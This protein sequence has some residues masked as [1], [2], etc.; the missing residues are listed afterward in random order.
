MQERPEQNG[1]EIEQA[2]EVVLARITHRELWDE[3]E[4][5]AVGKQL[6]DLLQRDHCRRLVVSLSAVHELGSAML[7][8][9]IMLHKEA[10]VAGGRLALCGL[11]PPLQRALEEARL[12]QFFNIYRDEQ[13]AARSQ[14]P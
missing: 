6:S 4:I 11:A 9:L 10:E 13:E 8:K 7:G 1:L 2:G 14:L 3:E 12:A 5:Q